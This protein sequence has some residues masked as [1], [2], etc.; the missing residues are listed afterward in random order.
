MKKY[1]KSQKRAA[2]GRSL[3]NRDGFWIA[4]IVVLSL[5]YI[6]FAFI[7]I[8][9]RDLSFDA[10]RN[11]LTTLFA[12][13]SALAFWLQ[14]KKTERLNESNYVMNLNNQFINN[15]NMT[16]IEHQLEL[17]FNQYS[18][19]K[20]RKAGSGTASAS[21]TADDVSGIHL[22]IN[23]SRTSEECQDLIDYLVYLES[24]AVMVQNGVIRINDV[25]D[26]FSYRF[27]LAV[28][29]PVVQ[30]Q[31][32]LPF[33]D[34][35]RGTYTLCKKWVK[36]HRKKKIP[37]PMEE[38]CLTFDRLEKWREINKITP[39]HSVIKSAEYQKPH[40]DCGFARSVDNK[41][42]IALCLFET[43]PFIYP[44]AFGDDRDSAVDA[45]SKIIGMDGSLFDYNNLFLARY[46][47]Q[48]CGVVC[49]YSGGKKWDKERIR[50]RIGEDFYSTEAREEGFECASKNYFD[51]YYNRVDFPQETVELVAVCVEEGYRNRGIAKELLQALFI[52]PVCKGKTITLTVLTNNT[53]AKE[54]YQTLSFTETGNKKKGFGPIGQEP[55]VIEMKRIANSTI[56]AKD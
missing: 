11:R 2:S 42:E 40:I 50:K 48:V 46:N 16:K 47:G 56:C 34:F 28:N 43:D 31:E 39:E 27:F 49:L 22:G 13:V 37:I 17:Y 9:T 55:D 20:K 26:L 24:L 33:S 1:S 7:N 18:E 15:K 10:I 3:L 35:Y 51:L 5:V 44:E 30:E 53:E 32:L 4:V 52:E 36:G 23:L 19:I 38:F 29:N 41:K 21:M 25:D 6:F 14:F 12:I 54:F 8:S 45:I